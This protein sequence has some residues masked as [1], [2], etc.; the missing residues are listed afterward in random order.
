MA[1]LISIHP[2]LRLQMSH[3]DPPSAI[4]SARSMRYVSIMRRATYGVISFDHIGV[5]FVMLMKALTLAIATP[6][7]ALMRAAS[8]WGAILCCSL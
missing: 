1:L 3:A 2:T 8:S 4:R 5:A 7:F 6:M